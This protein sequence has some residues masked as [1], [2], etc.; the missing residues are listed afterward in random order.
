[1]VP[2]RQ[3]NNMKLPLEKSVINIQLKPSDISL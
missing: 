2:D 3:V 1:M